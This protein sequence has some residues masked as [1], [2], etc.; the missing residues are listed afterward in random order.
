MKVF[1]Y[2]KD[3]EL[4]PEEKRTGYLSYRHLFYDDEN[5]LLCNNIA[6]DYENMELYSGSNYDEE[7]DEYCDI[8]QYYLID[9]SKAERL[10]EF[11]DEIIYYNNNLDL[12]VLGVTHFGTS[13]DY[14]MTD[15]KLKQ[16]GE[17][18]VAYIDEQE[19]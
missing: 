17:R 13:W 4:S 16:D 8:Y 2:L 15:I 3:E 1:R 12:Y 6:N 10:A 11:T 7:Y 18:W 5:C 9:E 19:D 14:V